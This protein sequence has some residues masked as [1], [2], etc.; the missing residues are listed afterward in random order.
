MQ[1][2]NKDVTKENPSEIQNGFSDFLMFQ[3]LHVFLYNMFRITDYN[4]ISHVVM[5]SWLDLSVILFLYT[6]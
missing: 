3:L 4:N 1:T 5:T 6:I 2:G